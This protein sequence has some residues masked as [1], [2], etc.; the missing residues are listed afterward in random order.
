M[1]F[2]PLLQLAGDLSADDNR[3][4]RSHHP[5]ALLLRGRACVISPG[6]L[7]LAGSAEMRAPSHVGQ[8]GRVRAVSN[9][10]IWRRAP[11]R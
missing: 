7:E 11:N 6:I 1:M 4:L 9:D 2:G 8:M 3:P 5:A 10:G